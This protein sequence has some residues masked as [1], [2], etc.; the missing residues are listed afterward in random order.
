[1][2]L[3]GHVV[4]SLVAM[5]INLWQS[6]MNEVYRPV[7]RLSHGLVLPN[8]IAGLVLAGLIFAWIYLSTGN[9]WFSIG[10]HALINA[11]TPVLASPLD[12]NGTYQ[13]ILLFG[14]LRTVPRA[15]TAPTDCVPVT[16]W[17]GRSAG[18]LRAPVTAGSVTAAAAP[19]DRS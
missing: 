10:L 2:L 12:A 17:T 13:I 19:S 18:D 9:L 3:L 5:P 4:I 15:S 1:V 16:T 14:V 6:L 8:L 7:L 11:P